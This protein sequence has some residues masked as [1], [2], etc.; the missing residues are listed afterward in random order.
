MGAIC[1]HCMHMLVRCSHELCIR[2]Q[3][4]ALSFP[5]V[6]EDAFASGPVALRSYAKKMR[7]GTVLD[8]T[9]YPSRCLPTSG[10]T[11]CNT[12]TLSQLPICNFCV[13]F[14]YL[15]VPIIK[16]RCWILLSNTWKRWSTQSTTYGMDAL[17]CSIISAHE[18]YS[19]C[20]HPSIHPSVCV[21]LCVSVCVL[22]RWST[23]HAQTMFR[24][25]ASSAPKAP[26][27][28]LYVYYLSICLLGS[29]CQ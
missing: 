25:H 19:T 10:A 28:I 22:Y 14:Y 21:Y 9:P 15:H 4:P 16:I 1:T 12:I 3:R 26:H 7:W 24:E 18:T 20:I 27:N 29:H 11:D 8:I 2:N 17:Y 6:I 23:F 13:S 5:E